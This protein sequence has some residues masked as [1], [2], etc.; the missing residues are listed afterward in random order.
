MVGDGWHGN[1]ARPATSFNSGGYL[2]LTTRGSGW[3]EMK[4]GAALDMVES[5]QGVR[6]FYRSGNGGRRTVKE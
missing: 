1:R 5:S 6:A 4:V 3:G 2:L